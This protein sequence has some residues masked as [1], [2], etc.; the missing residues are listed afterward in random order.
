MHSEV[1]LKPAFHLYILLSTNRALETSVGNGIGRSSTEDPIVD[2]AFSYYCVTDHHKV[3]DRGKVSKVGRT[4][5]GP[6]TEDWLYIGTCIVEL[7]DEQHPRQQ[8]PTTTRPK[9]SP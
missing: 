7:V 9:Q 5:C 6:E 8:A 1:E 2:L 3:R 4:Y